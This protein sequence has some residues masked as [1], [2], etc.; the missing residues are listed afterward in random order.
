MLELA[1]EAVVVPFRDP[2]RIA[3]SRLDIRLKISFQQLV[4]RNVIV[5]V[6]ANAEHA[7][8]VVV[9]CSAERRGVHVRCVA[10][11]VYGRKTKVIYE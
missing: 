8:D 10:H 9:D 3:R 2:F 4:D 6:V 1:H 5:V 11:S 7:V